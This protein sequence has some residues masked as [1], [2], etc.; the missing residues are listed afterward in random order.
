V[1]YLIP[2][3][4][5]SDPDV[6]LAAVRALGKIEDPRSVE[7]LISVL[8]DKRDGVRNEAEWILRRLT[9][10]N[11]GKDYQSWKRWWDSRSGSKQP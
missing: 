8:Q 5:D 11:P 7:P 6:R 9:G 1:E 4:K 3:L 2:L 10:E